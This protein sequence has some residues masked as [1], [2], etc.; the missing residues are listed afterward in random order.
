MTTKLLLLR[1]GQTDWNLQRRYQGQI[2]INLN[3][4]GISQA[5]DAA[6]S[7]IG[8]K[9]D[10]LYSSDLSRAV[11]TANEVAK[12][13]NLPIKKDARLREIKQGLWEGKLIDEIT[14]NQSELVNSIYEHPFQFQKPG[15]ESI[16]DLADRVWQ[17]LHDIAADHSSQTVV[18]V[19]HGL[20][21][22]TAICKFNHISLSMAKDYIPDNCEIVPLNWD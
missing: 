5:I 6:N 11:Q 9:I 12:V 4:T 22:S 2:D 1:H 3:K 10:S 13:V 18:V 15:G 14:N 21:I 8:Q 16:G 19:S 20:A 7:L 17:C